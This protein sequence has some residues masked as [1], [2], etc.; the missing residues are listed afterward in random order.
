MRI[1]K[2][3]VNS[4]VVFIEICINYSYNLNT[5]LMKKLFTL[6][7][8]VGTYFFCLAASMFLAYALKYAFSIPVCVQEVM[9]QQIG[10]LVPI[11]LLLLI[12]L[13]EFKGIFAYFRLPDLVKIVSVFSVFINHKVFF[14]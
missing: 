12:A 10:I 1:M 3:S 4:I 13:G 2:L 9:W 8:K 7:L 5:M 6:T 14:I 11:K